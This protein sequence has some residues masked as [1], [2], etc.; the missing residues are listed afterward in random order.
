MFTQITIFGAT[1]TLA[2]FAMILTATACATFAYVRYFRHTLSDKIKPNPVSW[3]IWGVTTLV[4][5]FTYNVFTNNLFQSL[6]FYWSGICCLFVTYAV[7]KALRKVK[8]EDRKTTPL[9][10]TDWLSI[11]FT[12]VA[13]VVLFGFHEEWWAHFI[14]IL[15]VVVSF[16]PI[17][18]ETWNEPDHEHAT[19]WVFWSIGDLLA[20]ILILS[21]LTGD[22]RE[23]WYAGIEFACHFGMLLIVIGRQSRFARRRNTLAT[24]ARKR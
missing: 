17:W 23:T 22:Y 13:L 4:E 11:G 16:V 12:I 2:S 5:A 21:Q 24:L 19:S 9:G 18:K 10:I 8:K 20:F 14:M 3:G 7:W 1:E 6:I 15:A